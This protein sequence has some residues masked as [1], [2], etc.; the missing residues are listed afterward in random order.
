MLDWFCGRA[1]WETCS[2]TSQKQTLAS[3]LCTK[4]GSGFCWLSVTQFLSC[5]RLFWREANMT[6]VVLA[7]QPTHPQAK[8]PGG[9]QCFDHLRECQSSN[10]WFAQPLRAPHP[11]SQKPLSTQHET[12]RSASVFSMLGE[13]EG[14]FLSLP[15]CLPGAPLQARLPHPATPPRNTPSKSSARGFCPP[16]DPLQPATGTSPRS[17]TSRPACTTSVPRRDTRGSSAGAWEPM[18]QPAKW[19]AWTLETGGRTRGVVSGDGVGGGV[20]HG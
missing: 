2:R 11:T 9:T 12:Q 1:L 3:F 13:A 14:A 16:Q 15:S 6:P 7:S 20:A 10:P 18:L 4:E 19:P 17:S 5:T 8:E